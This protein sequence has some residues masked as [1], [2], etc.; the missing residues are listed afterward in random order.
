MDI[1]RRYRRKRRT[2][3]V[4]KSVLFSVLV[5]VLFTGA[6]WGLWSSYFRVQTIT[7]EGAA[8]GQK[9]AAVIRG[10]FQKTRR[11]FAPAD[12]IFFVDIDGAREVLQEERIG[13]SEISKRYPQTLRVAFRERVPRFI[14]CGGDSSCY[15]IDE[16]GL[17]AAEAPQFSDA[18][19]PL[20]TFSVSTAVSD[21]SLG[22]WIVEPSVAQ[23]LSEFIALIERQFN[24]SISAIELQ[25]RK[26]EITAIPADVIE[27]KI[28]T[29]DDWFIFVRASDDPQ[30]LASDAALLIKEKIPT[31]EKLAYIDLRF[32]DKAF[33]K[34]R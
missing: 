12:S 5:F 25:P 14:W 9:V 18:P 34:L 6:G 24:V 22:Q 31:L 28:F 29:K 32:K 7:I 19:L 4:K 23:F 11:W 13:I 20:I 30:R 16:D 15:Y 26:E 8:D 10:Y 1:S 17:I 2:A 27:A 3:W 21:I 33:Y